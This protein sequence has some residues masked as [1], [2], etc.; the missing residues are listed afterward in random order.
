MVH[1]DQLASEGRV[2]VFDRDDRRHVVLAGGRKRENAISGFEEVVAAMG[3]ACGRRQRCRGGS[4]SAAPA[5]A[6][7]R[8]AAGAVR[9][10]HAL[11][12]AAG[13]GALRARPQWRRRAAREDDAHLG[14][15]RP[16][17]RCARAP[18]SR[19]CARWTFTRR[20]QG[21]RRPH[22][23]PLARPGLR[24]PP[25]PRRP[26]ALRAPPGRARARQRAPRAPPVGADADSLGAGVA[27]PR[28]ACCAAD[29][30]MEPIVETVQTAEA[31]SRSTRSTSAL[32]AGRPRRLGSTTARGEEQR[33]AKSYPPALCSTTRAAEAGPAARHAAKA[34]ALAGPEGRGENRAPR[35]GEWPV[36]RLAE[37]LLL[38]GAAHAAPAA[39][40]RR[41]R[42]AVRRDGRLQQT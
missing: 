4:A 23:P 9:A 2:E 13:R 25:R 31:R 29:G 42:G 24:A 28:P 16:A 39:D 1:L 37:R 10:A 38:A 20:S 7:V 36:R 32:C 27:D 18:R 21:C 34:S 33:C 19:G 8:A 14:E 17:V 12:S 11:S 41:A 15:R 5:H 30:F 3:A 6:W 40:K 22:R 26:P 35:A